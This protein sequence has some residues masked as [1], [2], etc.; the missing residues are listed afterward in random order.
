MADILANRL[1][2]D[3]SFVDLDGFEQERDMWL[4]GWSF[5]R[6]LTEPKEANQYLN[7]LQSE[8]NSFIV[9]DGEKVSLKVF[10]PPAPWQEVE[11]WTDRTILEGSF[12]LKSGSRESFYNRIVVYYDYDESGGDREENFESAIIAVDAASQDRSEWAEVSTRVIKS[13]WMRSLAF[14]QPEGISGLRVYHVSKGNGS[15][16][17]TLFYDGTAKT[18]SWMAP[19]GLQ[20]E[21]VRLSQDGKYQVFDADRNRYIRVIAAISELPYS[22]ASAP[23]LITGG[24]GE[25]HAAALAQKLLNRFRDPVATASFEIDMNSIAFMN[26]FIKPSDLKDC[27]TG[28]ACG[29]GMTG[30]VRNRLMLT[31]VRPDFSTHKVSIEAVETK[32]HR[33]YA[34]I[35]ASGQN[36][37]GEASGKERA[38]GFVGGA[39]NSTGGEDGYY[40][41]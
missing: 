1:G 8:T 22:D 13:R 28:E 5:D 10:A 6:V 3:P 36:D 32:M 20:G 38:Y 34:F 18:L 16:E 25:T 29:M 2:I 31:S 33:R 23:V 19:G 15:G 24:K 4:A 37:Y 26:R 21:P 17:G 27:T 35:A 14:S 7:E 41:W 9:H 39:G 11:E 12:S 40:I 30:W